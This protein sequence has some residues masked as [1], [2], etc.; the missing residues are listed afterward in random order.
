MAGKCF[1]LLPTLNATKWS[2]TCNT[3]RME[4]NKA[5]VKCDISEDKPRPFRSKAY[6]YLSM[7]LPSFLTAKTQIPFV[8][9]STMSVIK[10]NLHYLHPL[11]QWNFPHKES[12]MY[13]TDQFE[14]RG[15]LKLSDSFEVVQ[16]ILKPAGPFWIHKQMSI[17]LKQSKAALACCW[18]TLKPFALAAQTQTA[19]K[20]SV[21]RSLTAF[22]KL[23]FLCCRAASIASFVIH[24]STRIASLG[25][26]HYFI[27]LEKV[28]RF[29]IGCA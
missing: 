8:K 2:H 23:S 21:H 19:L 12:G 13:V 10:S 14:T 9:N 29:K 25:L 26:L 24:W 28:H 1:L 3:L 27:S 5:L 17:A 16:T 7:L 20:V 15:A 18:T 6:L 4:V 11:R 22:L